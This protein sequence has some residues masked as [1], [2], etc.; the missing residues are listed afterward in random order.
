MAGRGVYPKLAFIVAV[1]VG[2]FLLGSTMAQDVPKNVRAIIGKTESFGLGRYPI[3]FWSYTNL[4]EH[5]QYMDEAEVAEWAEAGFT[6]PQS[7]R[8][9]PDDSEQKAHML[10]LLDWAQ[11]HGLKLIFDSAQA[12]GAKVNGKYV[13]GF[14][15]MEVFSF[16]PSTVVT[17]IEGGMVTTDD[18]IL[19]KRI[20]EITGRRTEGR[21]WRT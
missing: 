2:T 16:S 1:A 19:A 4:A 18:D 13:G 7:P 6:V 5:G 17:A 12:L 9:D 14:G 11:K 10:R 15:D 8:C 3:S 20:C 21:T